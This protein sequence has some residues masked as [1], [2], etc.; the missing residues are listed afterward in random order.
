MI[1]RRAFDGGTLAPMTK[2][3]RLAATGPH[4]NVLGHVTRHE[5]KDLMAGT[6]IWNGFANRFLWFCVKRQKLV[7][8]PKR[9]PDAEVEAIAAEV[10]EAIMVAH[11]APG[12]LAMSEDASAL[13]GKLYPET[14]KDVP[15]IMGAV[16]ARQEAHV[17]RLALTYAQ[18]DT[19]SMITTTH[20]KAAVA[21]SQ[22]AFDSAAYLFGEF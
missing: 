2:R 8:F 9:M 6:E 5:L 18:L 3:D 7:P 15:G 12:E 1:I 17:Q 10:A 4:I 19:S 11:Q 20:L 16:T 14:T 13:W 21:V 22:Y